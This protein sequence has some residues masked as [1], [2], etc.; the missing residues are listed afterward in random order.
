M[1]ALQIVIALL[2]Q[3]LFSL[4]R[5][6][7]LALL[8]LRF[9]LV[10]LVVL[11]QFVRMPSPRE[12]ASL[13]VIRASFSSP[14]AGFALKVR[15]LVLHNIGLASIVAGVASLVSPALCHWRSAVRVGRPGSPGVRGRGIR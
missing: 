3:L 8:L 9:A 4:A 13:D 7:G 14:R 2:G 1:Y 10:V 6:T 12:P 5:F 15:V 11:G